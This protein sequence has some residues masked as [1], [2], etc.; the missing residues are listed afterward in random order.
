VNIVRKVAQE[1][2]IDWA[3]SAWSVTPVTQ[4]LQLQLLKIGQCEGNRS[5]EGFYTYKYRAIRHVSSLDFHFHSNEV[6]VDSELLM[7]ALS[8]GTGLVVLLSGGLDSSVLA[9]ALSYRGIPIKALTVIYGQRHSK[10]QEAAA[11]IAYK[12]GIE[13]KI[14]EIPE[15]RQLLG[16]QC[17]LVNEELLIPEG[18]YEAESMQ[19]TVVPN[20]NMI[21]LSL[22]TAWSVALHYGGIAYAAHAGDHAIYADC[23]PEF[24]D[25]VASAIALCD[26]SPQQLLRPFVHLKKDQIVAIGARLR[27]PF[28]LTWS[29]YK[30]GKQHCG[31]C[32]T[33]TERAEAFRL[34]GV[35][36]P[37]G[38]ELTETRSI[39]ELTS[40]SSDI[41]P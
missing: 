23:R 7:P 25:A 35:T 8:S 20:R 22:A 21:L 36:D 9:Y 1:I 5:D 31:R 39:K 10:E 14:L 2:K 24:A 26:D 27:V 12:L 33:C 29:C 38:Y 34:A 40:N 16:T 15:L 6:L 19:Q 11:A 37:T 30:G 18:H 41:H 3:K 17:A 32:G 13:H 4:D 28:E